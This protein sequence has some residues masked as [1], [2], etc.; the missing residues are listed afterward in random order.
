MDINSMYNTARAMI[1][2]V[3]AAR[4][5]AISDDAALCLI[6]TED[7]E[8]FTGI[9]SIR[10]TQDDVLTVSAEN[11]A[12]M[13]MISEQ[14][15]E[16]ANMITVSFSDYSICIP[17]EDSL[18]LLFRASDSNYNCNI[19]VSHEKMIAAQDMENFDAEDAQPE[20]QQ[21]DA[22][23]PFADNFDSAD[24]NSG[25]DFD[26]VTPDQPVQTLGSPAEFVSNITQD[27]NNPFYEAPSDAPA[28]GEPVSLNNMPEYNNTQPQSGY[29][30]QQPVHLFHGY[31]QVFRCFGIQQ[32]A[33]LL[34]S[35]SLV[36]IGVG[37]TVYNGTY[38]LFLDDRPDC[39]KIR[40]VEEGRLDAFH[41]YDIR[42]DVFIF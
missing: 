14:K 5:D 27:T 41:F 42:K 12:I 36:H 28:A 4:P 26:S 3:K 40:D 37:C 15:L 16:A 13:S 2:R 6:F 29:M 18:E 21:E 31:G 20:P 23:S 22:P 7:M 32:F 9:S 17:D 24:F 8:I 34:I 10:V 11:N 30:Y 38:F 35:F 19:A 39:F 1:D 33:E 25:F